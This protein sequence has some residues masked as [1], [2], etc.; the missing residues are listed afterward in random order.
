M[1]FIS[2]PKLISFCC[3]AE[4]RIKC[5]DVEASRKLSEQTMVKCLRNMDILKKAYAG[6]FMA[7]ILLADG[8]V[9]QKEEQFFF[10][11]KQR[12]NLPDLD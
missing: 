10:Y 4:T 3:A 12:L 1:F 9:T 11:M 7:Q 6:K 5:A 2:W 8:V